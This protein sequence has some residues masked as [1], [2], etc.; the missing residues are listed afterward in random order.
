VSQELCNKVLF[1]IKYQ[2]IPC[3]VDTKL[4]DER[5]FSSLKGKNPDDSGEIKILFGSAFNNPVKNYALVVK[6]IQILAN[7][8]IRVIELKSK[9]RNEVAELLSNCKLLIMTSLSEGSP[10]VIKEAMSC[11]RPIVSTDVGDIKEVVGD[12]EGCFL[13]GFKP[14]QVAES[15]CAALEYTNSNT[16]TNGRNRI[17]SLGLDSDSIA[18]RIRNVYMEALN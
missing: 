13:T 12:T 15:I 3:G 16:R 18:R 5:I 2:I 1:K 11:N 4:F 8:N 17:F 14:E 10:Q 6:A 7:P 9:S